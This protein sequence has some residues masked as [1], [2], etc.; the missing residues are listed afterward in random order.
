MTRHDFTR[1]A[2]VGHDLLTLKTT[3]PGILKGLIFSR[4]RIE[5]GDEM[6]WKVTMGR[7]VAVVEE[8][9]CVMDPDD[10]YEVTV[11]VIERI[12]NES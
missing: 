8:S 10:M 4:N 6:E 5:E 12:P 9:R 2:T 1:P 11:R 3:T 7:V